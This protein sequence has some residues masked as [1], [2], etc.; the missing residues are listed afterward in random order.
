MVVGLVVVGPG[1]VGL[2]VVRPGVVRPVVVGPVVVGPVIV[3]SG[4]GS[5]VVGSVVVGSVVA[6]VVEVTG[7]SAV[8]VGRPGRVPVVG[9]AQVGSGPNRAR[10]LTARVD[11]GGGTSG[12]RRSRR[13][14][15][16]VGAGDRTA[17]DGRGDVGW[18]TTGGSGAGGA[19][20]RTLTGVWYV[21]ACGCADG[22]GSGWPN[23][24]TSAAT[25]PAAAIGSTTTA[26]RHP[27]PPRGDAR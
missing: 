4:T 21:V 16:G 19:E 20:V 2:V 8:V 27:R 3:G 26:A 9:N 25:P 7:G 17:P 23:A 11:V 18:T 12:R 22:G 13:S 15:D 14:G 24:S 5:V 6:G 1:V 10:G